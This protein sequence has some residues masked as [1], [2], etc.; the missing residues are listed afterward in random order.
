MDEPTA[1]IDAQ[2]CQEIWNILKEERKTK[3]ILI[4]THYMD[5][6][7]AL[8]DMV[9]IMNKGQILH[10]D[11]PNNLKKRYSMYYVLYYTTILLLSKKSPDNY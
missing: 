9:L 3:T 6:A 11:T 5:E 7:D 10:Y 2:S 4:S 8:A 1:G